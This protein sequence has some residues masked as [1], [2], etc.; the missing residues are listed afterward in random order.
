ML[1]KNLEK[2]M[3]VK[4]EKVTIDKD[5]FFQILRA[6]VYESPYF[7]EKYYL[8]KNPDLKGTPFEENARLHY[9]QTGY[10]QHKS[11]GPMQIDED[12]YVKSNVDIKRALL[13]GKVK[14]LQQHYDANGFK[15]GRNPVAN[16]TIWKNL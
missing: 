4:G 6:A 1:F 16:F 12:F 9:A 15:E 13:T 14:K 10:F 2:V 11:P 5:L 8:T 3:N 7:D